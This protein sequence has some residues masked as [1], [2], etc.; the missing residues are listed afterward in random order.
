MSE[1]NQETGL[2][3]LDL[4]EMSMH[5]DVKKW[6]RFFE[7]PLKISAKITT[8][9]SY[10]NDVDQ[11]LST[12]SFWEKWLKHLQI[13]CKP[14]KGSFSA[15]ATSDTLIFIANHP[16]SLLDCI[17]VMAM[18]KQIRPDVKMLGNA[19]LQPFIGLTNDIVVD[20]DAIKSGSALLV[21]P[22]VWNAAIGELILNSAAS[23]I[24]IFSHTKKPYLYHSKP[25]IASFL[26]IRT[27]LKQRGNTLYYSIGKKI[28]FNHLHGLSA[29][30]ISD[31][32]Q[33]HLFQLKC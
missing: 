22:S 11:D 7:K 8:F 10:L 18:I 15:A 30:E 4:T 1:D 5:P 26:S 33:K 25:L 12:I 27:C 19:Y 16:L 24:P 31:E 13:F 6:I 2:I 32:I 28:S 29:K 3:K 23:V 21:F 17:A 14:I 9:E 20:I